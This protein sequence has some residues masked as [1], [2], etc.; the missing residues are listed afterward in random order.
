VVGTRVHAK[1]A[2]AIRSVHF[3]LTSGQ[4]V[5]GTSQ[6]FVDKLVFSR[7]DASVSNRRG[8]DKLGRL[9]RRVPFVLAT[10][11]PTA[12]VCGQ[13]VAFFAI[14]HSQDAIG[15]E[16]HRVG[17]PGSSRDRNLGV[18]MIATFS[19]RVCRLACTWNRKRTPLSP[20]V[21]VGVLTF[22]MAAVCRTLVVGM[23]LT[24]QQSLRQQ[25]PAA[26]NLV[27]RAINPCGF[28]FGW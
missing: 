19:A 6:Q 10:T 3:R 20:C 21:R 13:R 14:S 26:I 11:N 18:N 5:L 28:Y 4:R 12:S 25:Q 17:Y 16:L 22:I 23:R 1:V 8:I 15:A 27:P 24:V 9:P 7:C 2:I